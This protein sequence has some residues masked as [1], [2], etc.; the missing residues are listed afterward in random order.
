MREQQ[1]L[2]SIIVGVS[3]GFCISTFSCWHL[4]MRVAL[5]REV[6]IPLGS[7]PVEIDRFEIQT[8]DFTLFM[9]YA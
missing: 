3:I 7:F 4:R 6:H 2:C 8:Q 1:E 9:L 5:V